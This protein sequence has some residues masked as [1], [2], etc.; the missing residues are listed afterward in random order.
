MTSQNLRVFVSYS[1]E[2]LELYREVCSCLRKSGLSPISDADLRPA[3]GFTEQ[4]Q[5]DISHA[6]VM[7]PIL[8]P[9]SHAR[10]W[11]H[12]EIGFAA[13]LKIPCVPICVGEL[14]DGMIAALHGVVLSE[15]LDDLET[16]LSSVDFVGVVEQASEQAVPP[17][18]VAPEPEARSQAIHKYADEAFLRSGFQRVRIGGGLSSFSLPDELPDH[19]KW[20]AAYGDRPRSEYSYRLIRNEHLALKRHA[21]KAGLS[22]I[23]NIGLN[24]DQQRG[25]GVTRTRLCLLHEFLSGLTDDRVVIA[26]V[27]KHP[28]DVTLAV[29]DWFIAESQAAREIRGVLHTTFMAHAPTVRRSIADFDRRLTSTLQGQKVEPQDSRRRAL[30][31]IEAKVRE[32]PHHSAWSSLVDGA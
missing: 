31:L 9:R 19:P 32:L 2:D 28:P 29:G 30:E 22:M 26:V 3:Q 8:T 14:P 16:K 18:F 13:A 21:V 15:T 12:Q 6:H 10:G 27:R 11:V 7:V 24:L 23:V 25:P 4:I 1:H 20:S 5:V 17:S